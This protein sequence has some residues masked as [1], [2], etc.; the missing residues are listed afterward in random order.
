MATSVKEKRVNDNT[1][2]QRFQFKNVHSFSYFPFIVVLLFSISFALN[3]RIWITKELKDAAIYEG[4][5]DIMPE[6]KFQSLL[7]LLLLIL[8]F[9]LFSTLK[10]IGETSLRLSLLLFAKDQ[11][12]FTMRRMQAGFWI[13]VVGGVIAILLFK[14][15]ILVLVVFIVSVILYFVFYIFQLS[16]D[17]SLGSLVGIILFN[18][19]L[20]TTIFL[21]TFYFSIK[22]YNQLLNTIIA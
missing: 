14:S 8:F 16:E 4:I 1:P 15:T 6:A 7:L 10:L 17:L 13:L 20:W 2:K 12:G 18:T 21:F 11:T 9:M 3:I 22:T 5:I 19:L